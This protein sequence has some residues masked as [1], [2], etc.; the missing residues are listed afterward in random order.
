[1]L[2]SSSGRLSK[3]LDRTEIRRDFATALRSEKNGAALSG[4]LGWS[5]SDEDL[6]NLAKL[7]NSNK[8]RKKIEDMLTDCN[9]HY[10]CGLMSSKDYSKWLWFV[11]I[12]LPRRIPF[13]RNCGESKRIFF[14]TW[15]IIRKGEIL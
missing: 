9:F 4:T 12:S 14:F 10:E 6:K 13:G 3:R 1:M 8:F 11:T 5:F 15:I 7:H 2:G